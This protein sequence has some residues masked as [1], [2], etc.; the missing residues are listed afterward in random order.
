MRNIV[1]NRAKFISLWAPEKKSR[2]ML[3][4]RAKFSYGG[5]EIFLRRVGHVPLA[6]LVLLPNHPSSA[7]V[8]T[9]SLDVG[10]FAIY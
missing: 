7:L 8:H 5:V 9:I 6:V 2:E 4:Q 10:H 3:L 1:P